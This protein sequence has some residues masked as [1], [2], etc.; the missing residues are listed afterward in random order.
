M[1]RSKTSIFSFCC[2]YIF[3]FAIHCKPMAVTLPLVII[4]YYIIY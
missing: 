3:C 2:M 4:N 1:F